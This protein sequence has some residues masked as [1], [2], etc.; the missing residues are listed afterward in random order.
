[1]GI[2]R[3]I[4][5]LS[6]VY[7]HHL[8]TDSLT[9]NRDAAIS[10]LRLFVG[11]IGAC[12]VNAFF[13]MSGFYSQM[14]LEEKFAGR[15]GAVRRYYLFR[16]IR[17]M[18]TY[19]VALLLL[20]ALSGWVSLSPREPILLDQIKE[21]LILPSSLTDLHF[22]AKNLFLFNPYQL[23]FHDF[24][25]IEVQSYYALWPAWTLS[26]E[27]LFILM[28]PL[29]LARRTWF[30]YGFYLAV[31]CALYFASDG[32]FS[33]Y[34]GAT[35]LYFY[36][37]AFEYKLYKRHLLPRFD[38]ATRSRYLAGYGLVMILGLYVSYFVSLSA[39]MGVTRF[40][41]FCIIHVACFVPFIAAMTRFS[42][43]DRII[44]QLTYPIYLF[45]IPLFAVCL[46]L[47][48]EADVP[49]VLVGSLL[50]AALC[51]VG[52]EQPLRHWRYRLLAR[53]A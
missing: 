43:I 53:H 51:F 9:S 31:L 29:F 50:L 23:K 52:I 7:A 12:V 1:M 10:Y 3:L 17:L 39:W 44:G 24:R 27:I 8:I 4:L 13:L 20:A 16:L 2:F 33:G 28:A 42:K 41:V 21:L 25:F 37:G 32:I 47:G 11:P 22:W 34:F 36:L 46:L 14:L 18:P 19:L 26:L 15:P 40:Y 5:C 38:T 49:F 45:H 30:L 6:V 48:I 35:L